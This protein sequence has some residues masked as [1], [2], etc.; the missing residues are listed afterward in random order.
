MIL[1]KRTLGFTCPLWLGYW[2]LLVGCTTLPWGGFRE[3]D[4]VLVNGKIYTLTWG[5]P[6]AEGTP[7]PDAPRDLTGWHPDAEAIALGN[8]MILAVGSKREVLH[9]RGP[10]TRVIDLEGATVLP[11][12]V[13]THTH[14][15]EWGRSL[16]EVSLV[17]AKTPKE[18]IDRVLPRTERLKPGEWVLGHG[19]DEGAWAD[20]YPTADLLTDAIP[21]HPVL[22]RG[23]HGF[24]VWANRLALEQAGIDRDTK[25]PSGGM[26]LRDERGVATGILLNRATTLFEPAIPQ[27][28]IPELGEHLRLGLT[29]MAKEGYVG[30][31]EAGV[32]SRLLEAA[33]GLANEERLPIR[34]YAMLSA[35][36]PELLAHWLHRGPS[37][38]DGWLTVRSVKAYYD[39]ALG[40]RGA[41]LLEDYADRPGHRGVAGQ[42]Y[43]FDQALVAR[44]MKAGFQV[45][46]HAI[47]DAG[48]R[49][50]LDFFADVL[51]EDPDCRRY[52]HR[53]E[54]AQVVHPDDF[55]RFRE[56][57]IIASMEPPHAVEDMTWAEERVGPHRV[58][59]AYAWR[60]MR[61]NGIPLVFNSDLPGSD[62]DIFYGLHAAMTR[63]DKSKSPPEGWFPDQC[64]SPE[65]SIRAYTSWAAYAGFAEK[66]TGVLSPGFAGDLTVMTVDPFVVGESD[67]GAL[68]NGE[69]LMTIIAGKIVVDSRGDS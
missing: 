66:E 11:G 17:G 10:R 43:G 26:I 29:A 31:H 54:H 33:Q 1:W 32:G 53:I 22:L 34:F 67:P 59:G 18:A 27:T 15:A 44:M 38:G 28:S 3:A 39:G 52:R 30:V 58:R 41:R 21:D 36:D 60:T 19:W 51:E 50:T 61:R 62:P 69:I 65:E 20:S 35:R 64:L 68:L 42:E 5:E 55:P 13:D 49:E 24:A 6:D 7:A 63:R 2:L 16:S 48:N 47:G 37:R 12:F 57:K 45:G 40:S 9:H 23:L 46:V 4:L 14:V 8:G 56:M 25:A